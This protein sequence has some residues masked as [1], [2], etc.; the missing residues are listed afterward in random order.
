MHRTALIAAICGGLPIQFALSEDAL[1]LTNVTIN[2]IKHGGRGSFRIEAK[3]DNP[4]D[5]AV[6]DVRINCD[7]RE[8]RGKSLASYASK[9]T[10][11]IEAKEVR[12]IRRWISEHGRI[13]EGQPTAYRGKQ[14]GSRI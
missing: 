1:P 5:F 3:I 13:K 8:R 14:N 4:N 12:T 11:A 6:F 2:M 9:I 10:D 7:I